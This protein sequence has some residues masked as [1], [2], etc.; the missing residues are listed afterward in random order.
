[1]LAVIRTGGKQYIV[2]EK[3]RLRI[4]KIPA[5]KN[6]QVVFSDVLMI[7]ADGA[8]PTLGHPTVA[9]ATV[10][11]KVLEQGTAAKATSIKYKPKTRYKRTKGH[12][13]PFTEIEIT[14][15]TV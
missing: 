14:K 2:H 5:E 9:G 1:M 13:Q 12:R 15:I 7:A 10:E 6:G 8:V 11:A 4:E 3:S